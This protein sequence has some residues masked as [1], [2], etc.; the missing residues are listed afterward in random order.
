MTNQEVIETLTD[1][2]HYID[3]DKFGKR[4]IHEAVYLAIKAL[5]FIN[6]NYPETFKDYL[7]GFQIR[8]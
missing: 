2:E 8:E 4:N 1:M 7:S 6:E 3:R 5:K